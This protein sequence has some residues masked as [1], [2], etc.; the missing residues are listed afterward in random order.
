MASYYST[1]ISGIENDESLSSSEK[2]QKL[3]SI[4][5][6]VV[7]LRRASESPDDTDDTNDDLK[8]V[9]RALAKLE[10]QESNRAA[11]T[12]QL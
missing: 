1:M 10:G 12:S 11:S 2:I 3:K 4:A 5:S 6:Q 9:Q 7:D 8:A